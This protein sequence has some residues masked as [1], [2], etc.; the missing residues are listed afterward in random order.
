[1]NGKLAALFFS[2]SSEIFKG[3]TGVIPIS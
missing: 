1:V 3:L 2:D